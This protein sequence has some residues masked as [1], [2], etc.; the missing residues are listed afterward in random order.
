M[1]KLAGESTVTLIVNSFGCVSVELHT[2]LSTAAPAFAALKTKA[3]TQDPAG[4]GAQVVGVTVSTER[5]VPLGRQDR[6][7]NAPIGVTVTV[8]G[9]AWFT[10]AVAGMIER[11][12]AKFPGAVT[13]ALRDTVIAPV[14]VPIVRT[15]DAP[16]DASTAGLNAIVIVQDA[17]VA[18]TPV[19][20]V[21]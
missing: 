15:P 20:L 10:I 1:V 18:S 11:E 5:S 7:V 21:V 3:Y 19:Q 17:L 4:T 16:P 14:P 9:T 2:T 6:P 13:V 8:N 12:A